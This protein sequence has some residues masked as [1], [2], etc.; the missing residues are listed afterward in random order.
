MTREVSAIWRQGHEAADE[1]DANDNAQQCQRRTRPR[2][3][4]KNL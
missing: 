1:K 4:N 3:R 2:P